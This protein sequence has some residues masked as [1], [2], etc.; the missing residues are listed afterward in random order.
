MYEVH[1]KVFDSRSDQWSAPGVKGS[2]L[3]DETT[4]LYSDDD[5]G[6]DW[7]FADVPDHS[8]GDVRALGCL[9]FDAIAK[10]NHSATDIVLKMLGASL[11][12]S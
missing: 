11:A 10:I 1:S 7:D 3:R 9:D 12:G 2:Y 4:S 5:V 8:H 6:K